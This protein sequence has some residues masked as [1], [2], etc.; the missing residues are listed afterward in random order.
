VTKNVYSPDFCTSHPS[1]LMRRLSPAL[2]LML[3][4]FGCGPKPLPDHYQGKPLRHWQA[5]AASADPV[6]RRAAGKAL[7]KIGPK[8]LPAIVVLFQDPDA[9]VRTSA[10]LALVGMGRTAVP[11]LIELLRAPDPAVRM[12]AAKAITFV[13]ASAEEAGPALQEATGDSDDGVRK[14]AE[15]ALRRV[16]IRSLRAPPPPK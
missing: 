14:A 12:G 5:M 13:G 4:C 6:N 11:P 16:S 10:V 7:G 8:G 9:S 15:A 1:P 2:L 3:V